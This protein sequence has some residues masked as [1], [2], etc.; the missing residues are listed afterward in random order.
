MKRIVILIVL[1]LPFVVNAQY[2]QEVGLLFGASTYQGDLT[3]NNNRISTG[4]L[5]QALGIF[6][7]KSISSKLGFKVM[8]NYG[9]LSGDDADSKIEYLQARNLSFRSRLFE[10]GANL[11]WNLLGDDS[12]IQPYLY[13][14]ASTFYFKPETVYNGQIIELQPLGTEGQGLEGR[15][16]KY[17]LLSFAIPVGGGL[18]FKISDHINLGVDVGIRTTFTDYIDD[19]STTYV[20]FTDLAAGNGQLAA[21]VSYRGDEIPGIQ[22][23]PRIIET[24]DQ[25]GNSQAQDIYWVGGLTISYIIPSKTFHGSPKLRKDFGCPAGQ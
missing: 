23:D 16:N 8:A 12:R 15:P 2:N 20:N 22:D 17:R 18:R 1:G 14:G 4:P 13:A 9:T 25:R 3:P 11:E 19:V 10:L 6:Y 24:G 5:H 21:N 7:R